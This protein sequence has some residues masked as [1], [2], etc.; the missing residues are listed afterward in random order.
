MSIPMR[1]KRNGE[2]ILIREKSSQL[3]ELGIRRIIICDTENQEIVYQSIKA[4]EKDVE[5]VGL[6][7]SD[8]EKNEPLWMRENSVMK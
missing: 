5:I 8:R 1:M 4:F 3:S 2:L 7:H 6:Y